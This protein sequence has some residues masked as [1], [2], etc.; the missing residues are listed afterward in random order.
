MAQEPRDAVY[1]KDYR[2]FPF[3]LR[4]TALSFDVQSRDHVL[5]EASFELERIAQGPLV[6]SGKVYK[7]E[8]AFNLLAANGHLVE[9]LPAKTYDYLGASTL[10][11]FTDD[12]LP[13]SNPFKL[14]VTV[15]VDPAA[16]KTGEGL[17]Q[18]GDL[19]I[20]Q[21]EPEG[22]RA[23]VPSI[24][25]PDVMCPYSV[26]IHADK[27]EFPVL[28]SNG[29]LSMAVEDSVDGSHT[30]LYNDPWPKPSYLFALVV[31]QLFKLT[32]SF[33]SKGHEVPVILNI[34]SESEDTSKLE[35]AMQS[36]KKAF[37]WDEKTFGRA[38]DLGQFNIVTCQDFNVGAME[39]KSLNIFN[40][41][42]L[43]YRQDCSRDCDVT[44]VLRVVGHEYFHNWSGNRVTCRDWFQL[45]LKEGLTVYRDSVFQADVHSDVRRIED[46]R[47]L[48]GAQFPESA[49]TMQHP[50]RPQ[51]YESIDNFY[52][53]TVYYKGAE[54]IRMMCSLL[55]KD[56]FRRGTDH[57]FATHDGQACTCEDFI[58][59]LRE[60][61]VD[62]PE[63]VERL[64]NFERWYDAVE[65]P[66]VTLGEVD[67][68][69]GGI[70][71]T[72]SQ[73]SDPPLV[74]PIRTAF[75][76][77]ANKNIVLEELLVLN[78]ATKTFTIQ[79][80]SEPVVV[81]IMRGFSA[82]VHFAVT[83]EKREDD[84]FILANDNDSYSKYSTCQK[85]QENCILDFYSNLDGTV[86]P[87]DLID[88]ITKASMVNR[89]MVDLTISTVY[90]H[91][92]SNR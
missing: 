31:G 75:L 35:W 73:S 41:A 58:G 21:C 9:I 30:A 6:L 87:Q 80:I 8:P 13:S 28:L 29:N 1:M 64:T 51:R 68:V 39:N 23:I 36:L 78:E 24:D 76:S 85:L 44:R 25:R 7:T 65:T 55:G 2:P 90:D 43:L 15:V 10:Y 32:D 70:Q 83:S 54:I 62:K 81:S 5:V 53:A 57:Y 45:T 79:G 19:L 72:L 46:V 86:V 71:L 12:E 74:V 3:K 59:S 67:V 69:P 26:K 89:Y 48:Q 4:H 40:A 37:E 33:P 34:W 17:Y 91:I 77:K 22:F 60:A 61:N 49:S 82:P 11:S 20:T 52:T 66:T 27:K 56:N 88:A 42:C 16:N 47:L 63:L 50:I 92:R 14:V 18:S 38:Y 84:Y